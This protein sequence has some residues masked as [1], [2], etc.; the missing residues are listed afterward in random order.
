[1]NLERENAVEQMAKIAVFKPKEKSEKYNDEAIV[2]MTGW[3]LNVSPYTDLM[4]KLADESGLRVY[5]TDSPAGQRNKG[6][7]ALRARVKSVRLIFEQLK[8]DSVKG[9]ALLAHSEAATYSTVFAKIHQEIS[10]EEAGYSQ[11]PDIRQIV[12]IAPSG[13][14]RTNF[15]DLTLRYTGELLRSPFSS[16]T[17][18]TLKNFFT[19]KNFKAAWEA[20]NYMIK[21]SQRNKL[22]KHIKAL[23]DNGTDVCIVIAQGDIT[24]TENSLRESLNELSKKGLKIVSI[25]GTHNEA[26]SEDLSDFYLDIINGKI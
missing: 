13:I 16:P 11:F 1:M 4:Q 2:F 21:Y 25:A 24:F 14:A 26:I 8:E 3:M 5:A 7:M 9:V 22:L 19:P 6:D 12:L 15:P 23:L 20:V 17:L 18:N 10:L